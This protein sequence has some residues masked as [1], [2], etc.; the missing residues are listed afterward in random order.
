M[1]SINRTGKSNA[2]KGVE[3]HYNEYSEF[4]LRETEGHVVA[5][6]MEM[7]GM[8]NME[9]WKFINIML[10]YILIFFQ[11]LTFTVSGSVGFTSIFVPSKS[12]SS[13]LYPK[14]LILRS[15]LFFYQT[16]Q[17]PRQLKENGCF[18]Y[19]K[20]TSRSLS[21]M[22]MKWLAWLKRQQ[23]YN[24]QRL[25]D[26]DAGHKAVRQY[27]LI[28]LAESGNLAHYYLPYIEWPKHQTS[29]WPDF[30]SIKE[31]LWRVHACIP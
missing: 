28:I 2:A 27:M 31:M 16:Q 21:L 12:S 6:F 3:N 1:A 23:S 4:H 25:V 15:A 20:I 14:H 10:N 26:G 24:R 5:S 11:S 7:M 8:K 13:R 22:L 19:V 17:S 18:K 29:L 9:G 30:D